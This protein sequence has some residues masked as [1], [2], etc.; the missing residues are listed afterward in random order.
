MVHKQWGLGS[1]LSYGLS[2]RCCPIIPLSIFVDTVSHVCLYLN[3]N[4][5]YSISIYL[6][7]NSYHGWFPQNKGS[8]L[9]SFVFSS[10]WFTTINSWKVASG[11]FSH[12]S[13]R[14]MF[15]KHEEKGLGAAGRGGGALVVRKEYS[16][17]PLE[18]PLRTTEVAHPFSGFLDTWRC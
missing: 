3:W 8:L 13:W 7:L 11:E 5:L 14:G 1:Y 12:G 2:R 16:V 9:V 17:V 10:A 18:R 6:R 4:C 15:Y